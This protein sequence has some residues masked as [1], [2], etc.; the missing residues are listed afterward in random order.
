LKELFTVRGAGTLIKRGTAIQ[1]RDS[2][3]ELD[4]GRLRQLLESSFQRALDP[5]FF[6]R[7]PLAIY[8]EASY[9][10]AL[11]VHHERPAPYLTKFAV[12]PEAQG[13][14]IGND[15]WQ[16][17][18]RDFPRLFWRGRPDNPINSWYQ[19]VCDG[20]LRLPRWQLFWRGIE[21]AQI[22]EIAARADALPSDFGGQREA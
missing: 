12:E 4:L 17:M 19:S 2:Y 22:A 7:A 16:A 21:P 3:A 20:M 9:R 11:I 8:F 14:G 13:E 5:D 1:R 6:E 15:L 18:L 10:G